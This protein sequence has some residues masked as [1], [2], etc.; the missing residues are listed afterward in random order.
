MPLHFASLV[1]LASSPGA[2]VLS[3]Y[4]I[5]SLPTS[6][7]LP[8]TLSTRSPGKAQLNLRM[9][10]IL[11]ENYC[12]GDVQDAAASLGRWQTDDFERARRFPDSLNM[13]QR[14]LAA[15]MHI[16]TLELQWRRETG[17]I[18]MDHAT[19]SQSFALGAGPFVPAQAEPL[20]KLW[21]L[22]LGYLYLS[23]L[24]LAQA[25]AHF[26]RA[27]STFPND[28]DILVATGV[29]H[30]I[31]TTALRWGAGTSAA[32]VSQHRV[33]SSNAHR[34]KA[35]SFFSKALAA[36]GDHPEALLRL[37]RL[38]FTAGAYDKAEALFEQVE[39]S[40][41]DQ[42]SLYLAHLFHGLLLERQEHV[43]G[44]KA[45]YERAISVQ[46]DSQTAYVALAALQ[47][48]TGDRSSAYEVAQRFD[49]T[50]SSTLS[51]P[52]GEYLF[53]RSTRVLEVARAAR[54]ILGCP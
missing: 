17:S 26:M 18:A 25:E 54:R 42:R 47:L 30:E 23:H 31:Q 51:D 7:Y 24:A 19:L 3:V 6:S 1:L 41:R 49:G 48:R 2:V 45:H 4:L 39:R 52:W 37:G 43:A 32:R 28:P 20:A 21:S 35:F 10:S 9:Y 29:V 36:D 11:L 22:S 13:R 38:H 8:H 15:F 53:A 12:R 40:D 46:P 34:G 14:M 27:R 16:E 33:P 44:A 5:S 50:R